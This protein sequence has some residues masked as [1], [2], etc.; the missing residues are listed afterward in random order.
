M[1]A[2]AGERLV[3]IGDA[4]H[5]ASPQLGQGANMALLDAA[6]VTAA[7]ALT[8]D[9]RDVPA[10]AVHLRAAHVTLYQSITA[11]F[12]PLYQSQQGWPANLRDRVLAP[13]SRYWPGR[14]IQAR[15]LSGLVG[16]P[17]HRL[18]LERHDYSALPEPG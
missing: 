2:P 5:T 12:T 9:P 16:R 1:R 14:T 3:H 8:G 18:G 17:L 6:A 7:L 15:L 13:A 4:W 10:M 11:L